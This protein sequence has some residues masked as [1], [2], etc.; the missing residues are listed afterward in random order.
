M[1]NTTIV[2]DIPAGAK[3]VN[4]LGADPANGNG[5]TMSLRPVRFS[6]E[7]IWESPCFWMLLG[8]GLTLT[9]IYVLR[10]KL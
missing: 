3:N 6:M 4:G 7:S 9:A 10:K 5:I 1:Q 2:D 8:A